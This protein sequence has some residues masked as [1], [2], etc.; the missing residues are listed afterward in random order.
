MMELGQISLL[1]VLGM[2]VGAVF[3]S[4]GAAGGILA[5]FF[6]VSIIGV[7]DPNSVK[8]MA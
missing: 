6:L 8:P 2:I 1:L 3:S 5:S 4:I 7:A